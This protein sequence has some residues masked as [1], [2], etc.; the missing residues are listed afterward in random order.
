MNMNKK[1]ATNA[2]K[3]IIADIGYLTNLP[4]V[5]DAAV[6]VR[7]GSFARPLWLSDDP[8]DRNEDSNILR[9]WLVQDAWP[10]GVIGYGR[11]P[12]GLPFISLVS[13]FEPALGAELQRVADQM[14]GILVQLRQQK[15]RPHDESP[16][17]ALTFL[18]GPLE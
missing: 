14:E 17:L 3:G 7:C 10:L 15:D 8:E 18:L 2:A 6:V 12:E 5:E 9:N 13:P 4:F 16:R 1:D 11:D